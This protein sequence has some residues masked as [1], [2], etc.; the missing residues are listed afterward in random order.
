MLKYRST[1][2][3][4]CQDSGFL[5]NTFDLIF[6]FS[7]VREH[8]VADVEVLEVFCASKD[9]PGEHGHDVMR[10]VDVRQLVRDPTT[11]RKHFSSHERNLVV[12]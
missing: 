9:L 3:S 12:T 6:T 8:V 7:D 4:S 1:V 5:K 2:S 11:F 10:E